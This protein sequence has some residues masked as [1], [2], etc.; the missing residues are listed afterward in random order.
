MCLALN[1]SLEGTQWCQSYVLT[2]IPGFETD[3]PLSLLMVW[4]GYVF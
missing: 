1:S 2:T 4:G 3:L